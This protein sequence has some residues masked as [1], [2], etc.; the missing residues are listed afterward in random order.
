LGVN[1][2]DTAPSYADSEA[3]LGYAL[4][5]AP[6]PYFL[7]TKLGGRPLPF[8]AKNKEALRRS[9]EESRIASP[10][11]TSDTHYVVEWW[12]TMQPVTR[13]PT[14]SEASL[15]RLKTCYRCGEQYA[16]PPV[17]CVNCGAALMVLNRFRLWRRLRRAIRGMLP[18]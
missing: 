14:K 13:R 8:D 16:N 12:S 4:A 17:R 7:A 5:D 6:H 11:P 9:V 10:R 3:V 1:Y 15:L 2:V 18:E